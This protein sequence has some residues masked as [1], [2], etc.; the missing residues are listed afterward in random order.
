MCDRILG[1]LTPEERQAVTE[2]ARAARAKKALPAESRAPGKSE[3]PRP[4]GSC[5]P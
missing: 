2:H 1:Q 4:A 3:T 5:A